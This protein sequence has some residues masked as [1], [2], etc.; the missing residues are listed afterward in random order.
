MISEW[1]KICKSRPNAFVGSLLMLLVFVVAVIGSFYTP[2]D[3]IAVS[4]T[5][6]LAA[7]SLAH[8][9][10]TDEW[11]RDV[12]SRLLSAATVS[13]AISGITAIIATAIGA[14]IGAATA[15]YGGWFD[16]I[17]L[18][19]MD[20]LLAFPSLILALSVIA[21]YGSGEYA[22]IIALS[23]AYVP[24][25][26]RV[27]RTSGLSLKRR[28]FIDAS[29]IMGNS[30]FFTLLKHIL[31]NTLAPIIVLGTSLFGW[32]LLAES[33]LSFLGL[34]VSPPAASWGGM[35]ADSRYYFENA[36][37]LAV[38]PGLAISISLLGINLFGD[39]LRDYLDPR[40]KN[41]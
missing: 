12:L 13:V 26:V 1:W 5:E 29:A 40:M 34:G 25:V 22:V 23:I 11:G 3:P 32:A 20:S 10:G 36:P 18:V 30:R 27:V 17:M 37:W 19:F 2:Y 31:P 4:T 21:I 35:L 39:A 28:E 16:R 24:S 9:L 38:A 14:F 15:F 8:L 6:R 7:P 33:A 41:L